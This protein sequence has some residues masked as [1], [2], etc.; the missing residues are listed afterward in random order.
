MTEDSLTF[1]DAPRVQLDRLLDE[2]VERAQEVLT[3][4][5]R[6]RA[7]VRANQMVVEQLDLPAVLRRLV[8][9]AVELVD[10]QYGAL[11]VIAPGGGLEEFIHVG[12]TSE[13]AGLIGHL[14]QGRGLLGAV[15][16]DPRPI[17]LDDI[18]D[19]HRSAGFPEH[20]PPMNSF[21]GVPV[22][23]RNEVFGNLYLTN[24][25]SGS[26]G[27]DDEQLAI[28]LAGT[29]GLAIANARLFARAKRQE[30][31][32]AAA[33]EIT[34]ALP[35]IG[36]ADSLSLLVETVL[37]V[38][39]ADYVA[40]ALP[41]ADAHELSIEAALGSGVEATIGRTFPPTGTIAG[42]VFESRQPR[43]VEDSGAASPP[44]GAFPSGPAM[45]LPLTTSGRVHRVMVLGRTRGGARFTPDELDMAADFAA[46]A[47]IALELGR[48][49][50]D[51]ARMQL[52]EDRARIARDLH[53]H[54]IQQLF[55]TG[56]ELQR[57]VPDLPQTLSDT[58]SR[59]VARLDVA[60][61]QIR[62]AIFA[63]SATDGAAPSLRNQVI[64]VTNEL[65]AGLPRT[66][67]VAFS[68]P[69]DTLVTGE[70]AEDA[71]AVVREGLTN[72]VKHASARHATVRVA[73]EDD[74]VVVEVADDGQG[75]G[76]RQRWS[77][78][79]N[80]ERRAQ[81]R[82]GSFTFDSRAGATRIR[83]EVPVVHDAAGEQR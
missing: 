32:L 26:F 7:L 25:R 38:A 49:R 10:A 11:G 29:A 61:T 19:D 72:V 67:T 59:S 2:L 13:Q 79:A 24:A 44:S 82:G 74:C 9:V 14:P 55:A 48:R 54:V 6:L 80:L 73:A 58:V 30:A 27:P 43:L 57:V 46:Q 28:S 63:L 75:A 71:L 62:H 69:V 31:W 76:V 47:S 39:D 16:D 37:E 52:M 22:R 65:A 20:H 4:Q 51:R 77:G 41:T 23:V 68:G 78:L 17:R 36:L 3:T 1:P 12:M 35:E 81:R 8:E 15:I 70:I 53:D 34:A 83:W 56:L 21:L 45:A 33:A 64:E 5:S 66:P 60:I 50:E 18:A 42:S 40:V